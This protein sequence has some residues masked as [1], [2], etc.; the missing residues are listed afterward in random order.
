MFK[1]SWFYE[2]WLRFS[3]TWI[4]NCMRSKCIFLQFQANF[5]RSVRRSLIHIRNENGIRECTSYYCDDPDRSFRFRICL[6]CNL[7]FCDSVAKLQ[8]A[9]MYPVSQK[10][11]C[12]VQKFH[13]SRRENNFE[14]YRVNAAQIILLIS[15]NWQRI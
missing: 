6:F 9:V 2:K 1:N 15:R 8:V 4:F 13:I 14:G 12:K 7:V 11:G 3:E 10:S 5:I